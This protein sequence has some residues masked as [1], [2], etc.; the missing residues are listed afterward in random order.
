[1]VK[2]LFT[3]RNT[4]RDSPS[5]IENRRG[6]KEIEMTWSGKGRVNRGESNQASNQIPK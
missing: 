4:Q 2:E 1:M 6:R 3:V 5:Y